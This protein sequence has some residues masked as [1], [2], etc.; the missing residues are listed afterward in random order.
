MLNCF[1]R[2]HELSELSPKFMYSIF[3]RTDKED[4]IDVI[5]FQE[6]T[7]YLN[8]VQIIP[9]YNKHSKHICSWIR[10]VIAVNLRSIKYDWEFNVTCNY[11]ILLKHEY[12]ALQ[13][14]YFILLKHEYVALQK[15]KSVM[16]FK[17]VKFP[18]FLIIYYRPILRWNL[19]NLSRGLNPPKHNTKYNLKWNQPY[20][21]RGLN[22]NRR[23]NSL[24]SATDIY[25]KSCCFQLYKLADYLVLKLQHT[26]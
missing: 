9:L 17:P 10:G 3:L 18:Q 26:L 1:S 12:V 23:S 2:I 11:F 20:L 13:I 4:V 25:E 24:N 19:K 8:W 7:S 6:F 21:S 15:P 22:L 14:Y 16:L 5:A